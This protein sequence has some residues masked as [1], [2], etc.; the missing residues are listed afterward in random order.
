MGIYFCRHSGLVIRFNYLRTASQQNEK[1]LLAKIFTA[2]FAS[3]VR[4]KLTRSEL[5]ISVVQGHL[6]KNQTTKM[7]GEKTWHLKKSC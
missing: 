1:S 2:F 3:G 6:I 7:K 4:A 5:P